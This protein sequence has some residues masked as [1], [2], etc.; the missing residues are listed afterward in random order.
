MLSAAAAAPIAS[1][2]AAEA[3]LPSI[4]AQCEQP[5]RYRMSPAPLSRNRLNQFGTVVGITVSQTSTAE[6][7]LAT[8][9]GRSVAWYR[10][11]DGRY[12]AVCEDFPEK[13]LQTTVFTPQ[14]G[15]I[16]DRAV[17]QVL[18][19]DTSLFTFDQTYNYVLADRALSRP[20][21][22][23]R[24]YAYRPL[25]GGAPIMSEM[26]HLVVRVDA[27][28]TIARIE[29]GYPDLVP[30]PIAAPV[31]LDSTRTRLRRVCEAI[32]IARNHVTTV[33]VNSVTAERVSLA[34][35]QENR[36]GQLYLVP[37]LRCRLRCSLANGATAVKEECLSLDAS[38]QTYREVDPWLS[39]QAGK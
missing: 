31:P 27:R 29:A 3:A 24:T 6:C 30:E 23:Q 5:K 37:N 25:L 18:G 11:A 20:V 12:V 35:V 4:A 38:S 21:V 1:M 32:K 39:N 2:E 13:A 17:A 33:S 9:D 26:A 10:P 15:R 36:D 8:D 14:A 19:A 7:T 28:G 16:V 34:Y 22:Y